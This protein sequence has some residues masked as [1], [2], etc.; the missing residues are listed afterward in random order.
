MNTIKKYKCSCCGY[1]TLTDEPG[2]FDICS[3]CYW[4]DDNIQ[5]ADPDYVGGANGVSLNQ[6]RDN[7]KRFGVSDKCSLSSVRPPQEDEKPENNSDN[8]EETLE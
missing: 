1:F 6:A 4:E 7:Y 2:H 8:F 5:L 3:V